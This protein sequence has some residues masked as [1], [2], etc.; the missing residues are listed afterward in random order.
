MG[1]GD[2]ALHGVR[3][4]ISRYVF[5]Y[6]RYFCMKLTIYFYQTAG[7]QHYFCFHIDGENPKLVRCGGTHTLPAAVLNAS[8]TRS[9]F[10][11]V[12]TPTAG[13][14]TAICTAMA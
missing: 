13:V 3:S 2:G 14:A 8:L 7:S 1:C 4:N 6:T 5:I 9:R 12:S 10:S 11:G